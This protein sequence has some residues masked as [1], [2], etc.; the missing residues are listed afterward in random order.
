[1]VKQKKL[2]VIIFAGMALLAMILLSTT[3]S[4]TSLQQGEAINLPS[5]A[6]GGGQ[7]SA[8]FNG[9]F[10][11][12]FFAIVNLISFTALF[13][14]F[15]Y[16]LLTPER[17]KQLLKFLL[18]AVPVVA[19][20][21]F[22]ANYAHGC[23]KLTT[24][25]NQ[26]VLAPQPTLAGGT[27][28]PEAVFTPVTS[29]L[30]VIVAS[31]VLAVIISSLVVYLFMRARRES[32]RQVT[33]LMRLADQA[34]TALNTVQAGGDL[35]NAV[36]RCYYEMSR[37]LSEQ[38]GLKREQSMTPHEF[39]ARLVTNGLPAESVQLLTRLFEEVRYGTK[40]PGQREEWMAVTSLT[41]IVE[42]CRRSP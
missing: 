20:L 17:R 22:I 41:A 2:R 1:M 40:I 10:I 35:K 23:S 18:K 37:S 16:M 34:Q 36:L 7:Y 13:I 25:P 9:N 33:P 15:I 14:I 32:L 4:Q 21:L 38:L 42:A 3:L 26:A 8:L 31:V 11:E 39:E 24:V 6:L 30:I 5:K 29:P 19:V 27:P 28:V 12:I